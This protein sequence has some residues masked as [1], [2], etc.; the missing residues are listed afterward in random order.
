[1]SEK[2]KDAYTVIQIIA[3]VFTLLGFVLLVLGIL[4]ALS[5][6][7]ISEEMNLTIGV[8]GIV[9]GI[10]LELISIPFAK[11]LNKRCKSCHELLYGAE[12]SW[13]LIKEKVKQYKSNDGYELEY[14]LKYQIIFT[15]PHCG[16]VG[17]EKM[18]FT[19]KYNYSDCET[20]MLNYCMKKFGH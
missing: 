16:H 10:L 8:I 20:K 12:Y 9:V 3:T 1:M 5:I 19:S 13:T 2:K 11:Y 6:I 4:V 7:N 15:C 17:S 14:M 18:D